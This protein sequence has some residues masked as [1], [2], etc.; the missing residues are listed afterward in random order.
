MA[1]MYIV[2]CRDGSYYTGST[3]KDPEAR[4]WEHNHDEHLAARYTIKRRPVTLVYVEQFDRVDVAFCRE[5][6][7]QNWSRAKKEALIAGR[8]DELEHL[9]RSHA[10]SPST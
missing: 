3:E 8:V 1:F 9:S 2:R 4:V 5:K 10:S 6:Q 7:V